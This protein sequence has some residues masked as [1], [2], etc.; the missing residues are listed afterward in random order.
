MSIAFTAIQSGNDTI[1]CSNRYD[2]IEG[3]QGFINFNSHE[4]L[5]NMKLLIRFFHLI[6]K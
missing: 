4:R 3:Y 2:K 1:C 5:E 6:I